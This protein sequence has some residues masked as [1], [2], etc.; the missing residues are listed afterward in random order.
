M[1]VSISR[2]GDLMGGAI[3]YDVIETFAFKRGSY[4]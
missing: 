2:K 4:I 1:R 3:F